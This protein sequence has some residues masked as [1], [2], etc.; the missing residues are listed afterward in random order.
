MM[1]RRKK[2]IRPWM[3]PSIDIVVHV[4]GGMDAMVWLVRI[5]II[6]MTIMI[7]TSE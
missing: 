5:V 6:M 7:L 2:K 3:V 1:K 4:R